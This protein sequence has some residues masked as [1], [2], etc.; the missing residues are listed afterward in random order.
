MQRVIR[1]L[2]R[3]EV[4]EAICVIFAIVAE[5]LADRKPEE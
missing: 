3:P 1:W 5:E 4:L 2:L